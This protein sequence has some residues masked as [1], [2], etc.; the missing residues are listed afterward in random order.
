MRAMRERVRV[1]DIHAWTRGFLDVLAQVDQPTTTKTL[2]RRDAEGLAAE[3][4]AAPALVLLLDHDG[5]LVDLAPT[6]DAAAPDAPLLVLLTRLASQPN[7]AVHVISGRSPD[8]L[9]RWY[10]A[11]PIH[12]H[13]EHGA[14]WRPPGGDWSVSDATLEPWRARILEVMSSFATRTAGAFVE[15]KS[16]ALAWHYRGA[17]PEFGAAAA[18]ELRHHL[19]ALLASAPV[20]II[21]GNKVVEARPIGVDKGQAARRALALAPPGARVLAIGDDRTDEDLFAA[22]PADG[23]TIA[24]G[25]NVAQASWRLPDPT[26]VR[27]FLGDLRPRETDATPRRKAQGAT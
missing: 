27:W 26:A 20:E 19:R 14:L 22:V 25:D 9:T 24:V 6:P 21:A 18:R 12:L 11:L 3:L 7:T 10:G 17:D 5:T 8:S 1:H 13:A 16:V 2:T 4:S 15:E 23:V